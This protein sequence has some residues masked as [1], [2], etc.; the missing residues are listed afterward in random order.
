MKTCSKLIK[1]L[2]KVKRYGRTDEQTDRQSDLKEKVSIF[3]EKKGFHLSF[4]ALRGS[5]GDSGA[6]WGPF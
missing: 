1:T 4:G 2:K 3:L 6:E 5:W